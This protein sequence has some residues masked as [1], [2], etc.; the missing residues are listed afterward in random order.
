MNTG[1][2]M[3]PIYHFRQVSIYS[4]QSLTSIVYSTAHVRV[5]YPNLRY[6]SSDRITTPGPVSLESAQFCHTGIGILASCWKPQ[7]FRKSNYMDVEC[8]KLRTNLV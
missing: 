6:T 1:Q 8:Q 7:H 4:R 3:M 5:C 2:A